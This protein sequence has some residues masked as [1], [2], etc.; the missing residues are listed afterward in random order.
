MKKDSFDQHTGEDIEQTKTA[1][2]HEEKILSNIK[3]ILDY[4]DFGCVSPI[5]F[6]VVL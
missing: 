2:H 5:W 3:K 6:V 4:R 1:Y